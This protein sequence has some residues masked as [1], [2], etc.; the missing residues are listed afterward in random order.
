MGVNISIVDMRTGA[1]VPGWDWCRHAGDRR[2][3]DVL[4]KVGYTSTPRGDLRDG[5][6]FARPDD[7]AAFRTAL[8]TAFDFNTE[9]WNQMCDLLTE[10]QN[11]G[12][13]FS[14]WG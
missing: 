4:A 5:R 11:R 7:M 1:D 3:F 10:D 2:V 12:L 9:R 14:W 13:Y 6:S 8:H